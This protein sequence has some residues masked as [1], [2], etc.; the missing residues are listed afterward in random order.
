[1][2]AEGYII[3]APNRRG[4]P[5]FGVEWN[6][7]ISKDWG[8]QPMQDY[9]TAID[10][11]SKEPYV[12]SKRLGAIGASYGGYS[13]YYLAGIHQN[14]FKIFYSTLCKDHFTF[15]EVINVEI[16]IKD[17]GSSEHAGVIPEIHHFE[18]EMI[19]MEKKQPIELSQNLRRVSAY[20]EKGKM[21]VRMHGAVTL[22]EGGAF[23][24]VMNMYKQYGTVP[25][26]VYNGLNYGT[27][28]NKM[29][30]MSAILEAYIAAY[31]EKIQMVI[32]AKL[33][34]KH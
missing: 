33:G 26:S 31:R 8:G 11:V 30:E 9:L 2:A 34:K 14:R 15:T 19:R 22:G 10:E 27:T 12:D 1:M 3:V 16:L 6:E 29:G 20:V 24:D 28:R 32:D 5:G 4:M 13:I 7:A 18:S 25:Q 17:Q 23:H 21:Y